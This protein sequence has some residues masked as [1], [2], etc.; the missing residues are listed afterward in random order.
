MA[1]TMG[2]GKDSNTESLNSISLKRSIKSRSLRVKTLAFIFYSR[3][4]NKFRDV[5]YLFTYRTTFIF[6][7]PIIL[8]MSPP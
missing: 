1:N 2:V 8:R 7:A 3:N 6:H 5:L 4:Q